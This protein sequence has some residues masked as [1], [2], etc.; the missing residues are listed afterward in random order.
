MKNIEDI[1]LLS[2]ML[3]YQEQGIKKLLEEMRM[4]IK[5]TTEI[6]PMLRVF[7]CMFN[8]IDDKKDKGIILEF[9]QE[10]LDI[11][12]RKNMEE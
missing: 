6:V 8:I 11:L 9:I 7:L 12:K 4:T 10:Y 5:S 3:E 2:V 1:A